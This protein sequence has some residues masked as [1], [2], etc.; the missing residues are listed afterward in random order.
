[1]MKTA[2]RLLGGGAVCVG[3]CGLIFDSFGLHLVRDDCMSPVLLPGDLLLVQKRARAHRGDLVRV[4]ARDSLCRR[5]DEAVAANDDENVCLNCADAKPPPPKRKPH[6][7]VVRRLAAIEGDT[8]EGVW[9]G[10]STR[11]VPTRFDIPSCY[12]CLRA[13]NRDIPDFTDEGLV[14]FS[15]SFYTS[16]STRPVKA[17]LAWGAVPHRPHR[18]HQQPQ[19]QQVREAFVSDVVLYRLPAFPLRWQLPSLWGGRQP[20]PQPARAHPSSSLL[21][22]SASSPPSSSS[23]SPSSSLSSSP[24][25]GVKVPPERRGLTRVIAL[26]PFADFID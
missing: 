19:Q 22:R 11:R 2:S 14:R 24:S 20:E 18:L 15:L 6:R 12:C 13:D 16:G 7:R 21:S 3:V 25:A 8:V 26:S 5:W 23:P 4:L 9:G 1:M 10:R 17:T